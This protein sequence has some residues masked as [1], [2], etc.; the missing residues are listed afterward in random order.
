MDVEN[1]RFIPEWIQCQC[2]CAK[3]MLIKL[4]MTIC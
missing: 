2:E 1:G 3:I 4:V